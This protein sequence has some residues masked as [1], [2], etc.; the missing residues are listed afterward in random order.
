MSQYK[1]PACFCC[2]LLVLALLG[3]IHIIPKS[4]SPPRQAFFATSDLCHCTKE[5][6]DLSHWFE[7]SLHPMLS[8]N[9][10]P[11]GNNTPPRVFPC[12]FAGIPHKMGRKHGPSNRLPV[13]RPFG[14]TGQRNATRGGFQMPP[15]S[16]KLVNF[17]TSGVINPKAPLVQ[18]TIIEFFDSMIRAE[19]QSKPL[20][21]NEN[22]IL[23]FW[24]PLPL[25][26]MKEG[27]LTPWLKV[28]GI[29]PRKTIFLLPHQLQFP[30]DHTLIPSHQVVSLLLKNSM[31]W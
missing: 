25:S 22:M 26:F 1:L 28:P 3:W 4:A 10:P 2:F 5:P 8:L 12:L 23:S 14:L 24:D 20:S 19:N 16:I 7:H 11:H 17:C 27:L 13:P 29:P 21:S 9:N 30:Q 31:I 18:C 15:A 6:H